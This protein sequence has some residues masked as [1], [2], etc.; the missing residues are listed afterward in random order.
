MIHG[1]IEMKDAI[2]DDYWEKLQDFCEFVD[3]KCKGAI[4]IKA[5]TVKAEQIMQG[6]DRMRGE[7]A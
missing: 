5:E 3:T 6:R 4:S 2:V 1:V 7:S